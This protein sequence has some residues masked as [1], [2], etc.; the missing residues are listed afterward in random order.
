MALR[1]YRFRHSTNV[2]RVALAL[3]Y[4]GLAVESVEVDPADRSVVQKVSGQELVPVLEHDGR[5]IVDSMEIVRYLED[6]VRR[7]PRLYPADP[8]RRA[9]VEVFID[10][11]N[12]VWKRPPNEITTELEAG[13]PDHER[14]QQLGAQ[15]TRWLGLF[16]RM[17]QGRDYLMGDALSAADV[18]VFPFLKYGLLGDDFLRREND[19]YLF[20]EV[21]VD[22]MPVEPD[23]RRLA[24]WIRRLDELPRA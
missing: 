20:H 11:F 19:S 4:K 7:E 18:A 6:E 21:L 1:L 14:V 13:A 3:A 5:V 12:K 2:E 10:W 17:L 16:E 22:W 9:E 24:A 8:A 15:L 23:H